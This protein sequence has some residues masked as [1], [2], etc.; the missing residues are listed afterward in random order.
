M[1]EKWRDIAGFEGL[2]SISSCGRVKSLS[3]ITNRSNRHSSFAY[4]RKEIILKPIVRSNGYYH[5]ALVKCGS[6]KQASI[7]RIVAQA[8]IEN[9]KGKPQVNH[10]DGDKLNNA[11][12]NLEWCT[13]SENSIHARD[14]I[15][16]SYHGT[17]RFGAE[18]NKSRAVDQLTIDGKLVKSWGSGVDIV[19]SN[20]KFDSG[21]I[22]R[23]CNG[24]AVSHKGYKWAFSHG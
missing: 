1:D 18:S 11:L 3:R 5:V 4:N 20:R 17:G 8:F 21:S 10:I 15:G 22:S 19:R 14:I 2:Y 16:I 24:K 9:P 23:C 12:S 7:H 13:A 6:V